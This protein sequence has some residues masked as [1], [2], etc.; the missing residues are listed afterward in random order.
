MRWTFC[1]ISVL[2]LAACYSPGSPQVGYHSKQPSAIKLP[3][4][5]LVPEP[6]Q[7]KMIIDQPQKIYSSYY[8]EVKKF[9]VPDHSYRIDP[10]TENVI[11]VGK[12]G[13]ILHIPPKCLVDKTGNPYSGEV[14]LHYK[15]F[16]NSTEMAFSGINMWYKNGTEELRFNSAGMFELNATTLT[17]EAVFVGKDKKID[18]DFN[19]VKNNPGTDF[20]RLDTKK[21]QWVKV[22]GL[23][24]EPVSQKDSSMVII[25]P[26]FYW[27]DGRRL[28]L[29]D[30]TLRIKRTVK[31]DA[32]CYFDPG[33]YYPDIVQNLSINRFG[34]YNCDQVYRLANKVTVN[35]KYV[36]AATSKELNNNK[37]LS[38]IDLNYNG[39]FSFDPIRFT[40]DAKSRNVL[41]LFTE[42]GNL[43]YFSEE[44]FH[45][46]KIEGEKEVTFKMTN[47]SEKVKS[48]ED[49]QKLL[50]L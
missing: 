45:T 24:R 27:G 49:L 43:Y 12:R 7:T 28:Q 29:I 22:S 15:E 9:E 4:D 38:L 19:L 6:S 13:T 3:F 16:S 18:V 8:E 10:K 5:R 32:N 46:Q 25:E 23:K 33:H 2:L 48:T 17:G 35:A 42:S 37:V 21:N 39:A 36:D 20:Y 14:I 34:V 1:I 50:H 30:S 47:I 26:V 11:K 41:L 44:S 31:G 40:C